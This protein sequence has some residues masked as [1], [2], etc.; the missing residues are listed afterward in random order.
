MPVSEAVARNRAGAPKRGAASRDRDRALRQVLDRAP[1]PAGHD[2]REL[3][4][5]AAR[6]DSRARLAFARSVFDEAIAANAEKLAEEMI[7]RALDGD[8]V[9]LLTIARTL[10]LPARYD[11]TRVKLEVGAIENLADVDAAR[12]RVAEAVFA[13]EVGVEDGGNLAKMLDSIASGIEREQRSALLVDMRTSLAATARS[14]V[15]ARVAMMTTRAELILNGG[16]LDGDEPTMIEGTAELDA[17][18]WR[19]FL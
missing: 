19:A 16:T 9:A 13:G 11:A 8:G 4:A 17:D 2:P 5:T 14:G 3:A 1:V 7:T 15:S 18:D 10:Q 6:Q 12:R